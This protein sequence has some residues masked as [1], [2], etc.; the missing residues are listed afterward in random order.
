[1]IIP[2]KYGTVLEIRVTVNNSA[3]R[4]PNCFNQNWIYIPASSVY[5]KNVICS[6]IIKV[7]L[8]YPARNKFVSLFVKQFVFNISEN[9][10]D[11]NIHSSNNKLYVNIVWFYGYSHGNILAKGFTS[12]C[13]TLH[14]EHYPDK[15]IH[16]L[17]FTF[18]FNPTPDCYFVVCPPIQ[19]DR[20]RS[21]IIQLVPPSV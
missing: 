13:G 18:Q 20:Q 14:L 8:D 6:G 12:Q 17:D 9:I 10:R 11:T 2:Y 7:N 16:Q 15:Q 3:H 5:N 4:T 19:T 1:M 21:C